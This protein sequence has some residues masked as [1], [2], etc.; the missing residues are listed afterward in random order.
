MRNEQCK[1][2]E[3][4]FFHFSLLITHFLFVPA[5][6]FLIFHSYAI[7]DIM[8]FTQTIEIPANRRIILEVPSEV[9]TGPVI[10]TF[11]P[12]MKTDMIEFADASTDEV[13]AAGDGI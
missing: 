3:P 1:S 13:L 4:A 9:P 8:T 11:S 2:S 12:V 7:I 10:L 6:H 5:V